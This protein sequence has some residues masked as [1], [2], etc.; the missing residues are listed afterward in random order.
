MAWGSSTPNVASRTA[1]RTTLMTQG[2]SSRDATEEKIID[3][4]RKTRAVAY[5]V[6]RPR[7]A[8]EQAALLPELLLPLIIAALEIVP[9]LAEWDDGR[10]ST[11]TWDAYHAVVLRCPT[12]SGQ[13]AGAYFCKVCDCALRDCF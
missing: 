10:W 11:Y 12:L 3:I 1:L 6:G 9:G 2:A 5:R 8:A 13:Y 4:I 7:D